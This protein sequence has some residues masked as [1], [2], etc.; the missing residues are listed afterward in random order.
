MPRWLRITIAAAL[1]IA[2]AFT[3]DWGSL[4]LH[5]AHMNGL[6]AGVAFVAVLLEMPANAMKWY[7]A[8]RL[9]DQRF[10]WSYLFRVGCMAFFFNNFL[11]SAIGGDVYRVYR[12]WSGTGDKSSALSAVF[13]ERLVGLCVLM[14]NG[15]VGALFLSEHALARAFVA[16][17][18][19][20][21][22]CGLILLPL[23]IRLARK[24]VLSQRFK[25]LAGIESMLGRVLRLRSEWVYLVV[26]SL[27]FQGLAAWVVLLCFA[28]VGSSIDVPTALLITAAAGLASVLP[29]SISGLGVVEGSIAGTAVALG[30]N[31]ETAVA[32][33]LLLRVLALAVSGLCGIFCFFDD[34]KLPQSDD[35]NLTL[36]LQ[37]N[38]SPS[39][40]SRISM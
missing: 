6:I 9:H 23:L 20:A 5:A 27:V 15:F 36:R 18:L 31:L 3:V 37:P 29:I 26:A 21:G 39:A 25:K 4:R 16:V 40:P 7:W 1:L 32:A 12:T 11:P 22:L 33:A 8:L 14:V 17:S 28:A 2:L 35:A 38:P 24:G 10:A 34:G 30:G 13:I 19:I